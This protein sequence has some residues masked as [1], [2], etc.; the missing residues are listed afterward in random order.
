[1]FDPDQP[2]EGSS[3][4]SAV[5]RSQLTS[6]K[7]L[8][9]AISAITQA[10]VDGVLTLDP[11]DPATAQ[12]S[13]IG[14]MLHFTFSIPRGQPGQ[15][16]Q[17]GQDGGPGPVGPQGPPF[18]NAVVDGV[19]TLPAGDPA[20]V[21]VSFDGS[22]VHFTFSIP[23]GQSGPPGEVTTAQMDTAIAAAVSTT[24]LNPT[25]VSPLAITFTDPPTAAELTQVQD[26]IN[27]LLG[28]LTRTL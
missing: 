16:G 19:T 11:N 18:A 6:L 9:D 24:A 17:S 27:A 15:T 20:S 5:M 13:A 7:A 12:V 1:M 10:Q 23:Q 28:A 22:L 25:S 2:A 26:K 14:N 21:S 8:I 3:L 4:S